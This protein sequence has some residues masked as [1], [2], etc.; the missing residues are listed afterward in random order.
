MCKKSRW[1]GILITAL[2]MMTVMFPL[3]A[4]GT[5]EKAAT[6]NYFSGRVETVSWEEE[7]IA[8]F[9]RLHPDIN[10]EF[11]FQ[12]D[13]SNVIK[14][15][16]AS[17][18]VPDITTVVNQ[19]FIDQGIFADISDAP[20]WDR[21]LPS[22]KD[23]CTDLKTGRQYK[24]AANVTMGGLFYNKEVFKEL[25]LSDAQTWDEFVANL[26]AIKAAYPDMTPMFLGGKDS[27][28]LGHFVEFWAHGIV[29]QDL[30]IPGSRRAFLENDV[31]WDAANGIMENFAEALLELKRKGLINDDAVTASYDNQKEAFANGEAA[32]INQG[33]WV[34]GD[35]VKINPDMEDNIG[36]GPFPSVVDGYEPM[37]LSAEDSVYAI[38]ADTEYM[39]EVMTFLEFMFSPEVQ[40]E[41]SEIRSMP[42]A[43]TDVTADWGPIKDDAKQVIER[44][45]NINFSTE[46]PAGLS[47]D[48]TGRLIQKLL[49]GDYDSAADFAARYQELWD[50][51]Y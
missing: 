32:V 3:I 22:V 43:F 19:E 26:E 12:K 5:A 30:G 18:E 49:N 27:W 21:I 51:A 28:T 7:K 4:E 6:V 1:N 31:T 45:V 20:F 17:G 8:E 39:D 10:V 16:L 24:V 48:D 46:A 35:I 37:V 36:F 44:Y 33:M 47:V 14:V 23:L 29:K 40:K 25:G 13:A 38:S 9:E 11:E 42:S 2:M 41:Y 34:V 15:K 50:D